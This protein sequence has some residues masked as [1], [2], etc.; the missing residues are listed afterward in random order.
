MLLRFFL[1]SSVVLKGL[2]SVKKSINNVIYWMRKTLRAKSKVVHFN[3]L[4]PYGSGHKKNV[5]ITI[6]QRIHDQIRYWP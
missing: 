6:V 4:A 1:E 5:D 2:Y 3:R